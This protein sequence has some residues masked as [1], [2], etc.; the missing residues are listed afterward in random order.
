MKLLIILVVDKMLKLPVSIPLRIIV[1]ELIKVLCNFKSQQILI[2]LMIG[3]IF[4][5]ALSECFQHAE[6]GNNVK[7]FF[8]PL[9]IFNVEFNEIPPEI[10]GD[11]KSDEATDKI[12]TIDID[13]TQSF[14]E[15]RQEFSRRHSSPC[16]CEFEFSLRDLGPTR[17]PRYHQ[18]K[19]CTKNS[20]NH[21]CTFGSKC[22]ELEQK[23]FVLTEI[24]EVSTS[25]KFFNYEEKKY[26]WTMVY[27]KIDCRCTHS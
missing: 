22:K 11:Q 16:S 17:H 14:I 15:K 12:K 1:N 5:G 2:S 27:L 26:D 4:R 21:H 8:E 18:E 7:P 13:D 25:E 23:V 9:N 19:I 3:L 6:G 20:R 10:L 24:T